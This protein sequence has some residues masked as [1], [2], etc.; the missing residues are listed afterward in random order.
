MPDSPESSAP[1]S[2]AHSFIPLVSRR[3]QRGQWLQKLQ[4][5]VPAAALLMTGAQGILHGERGF[6]LGLA[7]GEVVMSALLLRTLVKDFAEVRQS[8]GA[9]HAGHHAGHGG[10]GGIDWFDVFV[11]GVLTVE[12]LEHWHTHHRVPGPTILLAAVTLTLGLLHG[13]IARRRMLHIN[14]DGIWIGRRFFR[15][16]V[17]PWKDIDRID[18]EDKQ[19]RIVLHGG[20][21]WRIRLTSLPNASDVRAALVAARSRLPQPAPM[22]SVTSNRPS[23][24]TATS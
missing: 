22:T 21:T 8:H 16:F 17:A 20:K 14:D 2:A 9:A 7:I 1:D 19:A 12:A 3:R 11:A 5:A 6:A 10:H 4:H 24:S 23:T 18:L 15:R 13:R